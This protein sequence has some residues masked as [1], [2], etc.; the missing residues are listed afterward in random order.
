[1]G[2]LTVIRLGSLTIRKGRITVDSVAKEGRHSE[3]GMAV[4]VVGLVVLVGVT[5]IDTLDPHAME[6][7]PV[8]LGVEVPRDIEGIHHRLPHAV[9]L[10]RIDVVKYF[11]E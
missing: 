9:H 11:E 6:V 1:M 5:E 4:E 3:E 2:G 7:A 8:L 10:L